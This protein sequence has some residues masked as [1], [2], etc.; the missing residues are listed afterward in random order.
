LEFVDQT[1]ADDGSEEYKRQPVRRVRIPAASTFCLC[2]HRS[3]SGVKIQ[4]GRGCEQGTDGEDPHTA[5]RL[6]PLQCRLEV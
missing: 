3:A 1:R 5:D 2:L 6:P 4:N